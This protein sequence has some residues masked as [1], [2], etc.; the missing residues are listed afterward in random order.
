M[1]TISN[2]QVKRIER[3]MMKDDKLKNWNK[4]T[5]R[6]LEFTRKII[7]ISNVLN[8]VHLKIQIIS[9]TIK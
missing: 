8:P 3:K 2:S 4:T 1:T 7:A 9:K 6:M 5:T